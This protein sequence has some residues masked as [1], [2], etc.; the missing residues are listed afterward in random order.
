M[1]PFGVNRL[2]KKTQ[3]ATKTHIAEETHKTYKTRDSHSVRNITKALLSIMSML[4]TILE[5]ELT[6]WWSCLQVNQRASRCRNVC[7]LL[8][9]LLHT[10]TWAFSDVTVF[11]SLTFMWVMHL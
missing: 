5:E 8:T 11:V 10:L 3:E 1:V 6:L 9:S 4:K 7:S 2:V